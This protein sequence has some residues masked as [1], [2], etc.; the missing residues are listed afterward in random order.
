MP[1]TSQDAFEKLFPVKQPVSSEELRN[2]SN[3]MNKGKPQIRVD[4]TLV[5]AESNFWP[6]T[7][8]IATDFIGGQREPRESRVSVSDFDSCITGSNE[9]QYHGYKRE[10]RH[11]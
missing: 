5:A 11:R 3:S 9:S 8:S 1:E 2:R 4:N 6:R 10:S 7:S